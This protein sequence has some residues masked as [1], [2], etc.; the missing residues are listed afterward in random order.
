MYA[1][2]LSLLITNTINFTIQ[3]QDKTIA[4]VMSVYLILLNIWSMLFKQKWIMERIWKYLFHLY[5]LGWPQEKFLRVPLHLQ[6]SHKHVPISDF[7]DVRKPQTL[8]KAKTRES[9]RDSEDQE[10]KSF[11]PSTTD[12]LRAGKIS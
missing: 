7:K 6:F 11:T 3:E 9:L 10:H 1:T 8:P 2:N 12:I 5:R 4:S